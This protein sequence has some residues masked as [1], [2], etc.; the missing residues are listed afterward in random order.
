[1][2]SESHTWLF[3][4]FSKSLSSV[5]WRSR[6]L[7]PARLILRFLRI[8]LIFSFSDKQFFWEFEGQSTVRYTW[9]YCVWLVETTEE[10]LTWSLCKES[11]RCDTAGSTPLSDFT[12]MRLLLL[13]VFELLMSL[14]DIMS[15]K[16]SNTVLCSWRR[17]SA[18]CRKMCRGDVPVLLVTLNGMLFFE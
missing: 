14:K 16:A 13:F 3:I 12:W 7:F 10:W 5:T 4:R 6:S 1:M 18:T 17:K 9:H 11:L 2:I 8:S 15:F